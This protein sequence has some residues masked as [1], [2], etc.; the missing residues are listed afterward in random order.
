VKPLKALAIDLDLPLAALYARA[1]R[2]GMKLEKAKRSGRTYCV[3]TPEQE[4]A[5]SRKRSCW[6]SGTH[7]RALVLRALAKCEGPASV[8]EVA[9]VAEVNRVVTG[10]KL[11]EA[12]RVGQCERVKPG[13]YVL[14][15][16]RRAA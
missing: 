7:T 8:S 5:L 11:A 16:E 13:V 2:A 1:T 10:I 3:V 12:C 15:P 14:N 6:D 4:A 9:Q